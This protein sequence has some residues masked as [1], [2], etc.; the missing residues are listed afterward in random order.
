[1]AV[2]S[3]TLAW[4]IPGTEAPGGLQSW[5]RR[6]R[7]DQDDLRNTAAM[8][9]LPRRAGPGPPTANL[10]LLELTGLLRPLQGQAQVHPQ[11]PSLHHT[12]HPQA[13]ACLTRRCSS[14][15]FQFYQVPCFNLALGCLAWCS[16]W[17]VCA[18]YILQS[19]PCDT[20]STCSRPGPALLC[21]IPDALDLMSKSYHRFYIMHLKS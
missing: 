18:G 8:D 7:H 20:G 17:R 10:R 2:H 14:Q 9:R 13:P 3:S 12:P 5:G 16:A 11:K 15:T 4:R 6:V 1:M 21:F 19:V